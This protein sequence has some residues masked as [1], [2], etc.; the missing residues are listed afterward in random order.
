MKE[1]C[2]VMHYFVTHFSIANRHFFEIFG[3]NVS[4]LSKIIKS[5][6]WLKRIC[7]PLSFRATIAEQCNLSVIATLNYFLKENAQLNIYRYLNVQYFTR[8][9]SRNMSSSSRTHI[10]TVENCCSP[11]YLTAKITYVI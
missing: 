8:D 7:L 2:L 11:I 4:L 9:A 1:F 5:G 10:L 3:K 6:G